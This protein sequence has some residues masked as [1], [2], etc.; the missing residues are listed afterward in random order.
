MDLPTHD[1]LFAAA[2][3]SLRHLSPVERAATEQR[4]RKLADVVR[5]VLGGKAAK[6][7][8]FVERKKKVKKL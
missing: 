7:Q 2:L 5:G 3:K 8:E 4:L 6:K 1:S